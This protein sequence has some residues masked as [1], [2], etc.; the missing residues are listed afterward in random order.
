MRLTRPRAWAG[1][2]LLM[3]ASVASLAADTGLAWASLT[4]A[5]RQI[6]APLR[7]DWST[8]DANRQ[9]KWVE[10]AAKFPTLPAAERH[11]IQARMNEWAKLSPTERAAAR[12]QFQE[13]R[14]L[15]AEER[16]AQWQAY[17]ALPPEERSKLAQKAKPATRASQPA[18]ATSR[19]GSGNDNAKRNM[20]RPSSTAPRR[21]ITPTVVQARPGATTTTLSTR[22][23]PPL[24]N[25]AG[26][27]K[28]AATP[29]FVDTTTL[30]P[31]RGP[32][33]AAVQA[34]AS[35]ADASRKP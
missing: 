10:L 24:H 12:M 21:P 13:V 2:L 7:Q 18:G 35:A 28:I 4:P 14:R 27:P 8:I 32:Q 3:L 9:Q 6:L 22:S 11:R 31:R 1:T 25:Q 26:L 29:G 33:G 16:Q 20:V 5:Q 15:P 17:Q 34:A 23:A 19:A 30:L